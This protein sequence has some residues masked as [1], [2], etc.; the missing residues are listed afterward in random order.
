MQQNLVTT[1]DVL[2]NT[3]PDP[4]PDLHYDFDD[5]D[6]SYAEGVSDDIFDERDS[7]FSNQTHTTD[8][9]LVT[10]AQDQENQQLPGTPVPAVQHK[11]AAVFQH[12][13]KML[14][15]RTSNGQ[16]LEEWRMPTQAEFDL[17]RERGRII[18]T[19]G[20][21]TPPPVA[22]AET[23][24]AE[25]MSKWKKAAMWLAILG[26]VGGLGYFAYQKYQEKADNEDL[27]AGSEEL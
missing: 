8:S 19:P 14:V 18:H 10:L 27:D 11:L 24:P 4:D 17:L 20:A 1:G 13:G 16:R 23:P 26:G 7:V 9:E 3:G 15:A 2:V 25:G 5:D 21:A 6:E 12:D 22:A